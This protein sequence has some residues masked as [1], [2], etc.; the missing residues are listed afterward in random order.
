MGPF[1]QNE[2]SRVIQKN[3]YDLFILILPSK[4]SNFFKSNSMGFGATWVLGYVTLRVL[5]LLLALLKFKY[6]WIWKYTCPKLINH[7]FKYIPYLQ[8]RFLSFVLFPG[9]NNSNI[10]SVQSKLQQKSRDKNTKIQNQS[11]SL[12][13]A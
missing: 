3:Y 2:F 7:T 8:I 5:A 12:N 4:L 6:F 11:V 10:K 1:A 13:N 9:N